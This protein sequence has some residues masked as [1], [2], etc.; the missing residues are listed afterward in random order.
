MSSFASEY[1]FR[2]ESLFI[3]HKDTIFKLITLFPELKNYK[4]FKIKK[5][6]FVDLCFK[7]E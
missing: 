4:F 5:I 6:D 1:D 3:L 7:E 2:I